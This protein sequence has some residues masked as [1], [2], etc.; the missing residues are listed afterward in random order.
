[1]A[2]RL[3]WRVVVVELSVCHESKSFNFLMVGGVFFARRIPGTSE[4]L[5]T[6]GVL[7]WRGCSVSADCV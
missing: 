4:L 3:D 7:C 1:M 6:S 5:E 2:L